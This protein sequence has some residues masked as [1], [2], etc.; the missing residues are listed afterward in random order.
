MLH[1]DCVVETDW[2]QEH[3]DAPDL[4]ILDGSWHMPASGRD[5]KQD[6][7]QGRIP[8]AVFFDIDDIKD[9]ASPLPH[10][11]PSSVQFSSQMKKLGIGDGFRIVVYDGSGIFS[12]A[13]VWWMLRVMGHV[14]VK[15]LNGGFP[16]WVS[17]GRP[18]EDG[19]PTHRAQVHFTAQFNNALISDIDDMRTYI[20]GG[21]PQIVDARPSAR[22]KG[23][24]DE[25]R[26]GLRR[27]HM[28]NARNVPFNQVLN[29]DGTL[30]SAD[31]LRGIFEAA[32]LDPAKDVVATCGSG[33]TASVLALALARC[34]Q[35]QAAIYDGSWSEWGQ[36]NGLPVA[37]G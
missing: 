18:I 31:E 7:L 21:G 37:T 24:A 33:V 3:L 34:G 14:D 36:D 9:P 17:E 27:G 32:G 15:V 13:R 4:L 11:L 12:A 25:P 19:P 30:K 22:F 20:K 1:Q 8:G 26:A 28:P 6:Y 16:K 2:L 35:S 10:M 23:E 5:G 29:D